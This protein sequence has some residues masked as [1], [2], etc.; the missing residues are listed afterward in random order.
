MSADPAGGERPTVPAQLALVIHFHQ[1]VGDLDRVVQSATDRCYRP[2]L[3]L[4]E[5][6]PTVPATL[7]YSGCLLEWLEDHAPDVPDRLARLVR[8]G[9]VELLTGGY[10]EPILAA[11]PPRDRLAQISRL[12]AHLED[13]FGVRPQGLWLTERVWEP[14]LP[15]TL[16]DAGVRYTVVD[17]SALRAVG[18]PV[19]A[20]RHGPH[21]T[22]SDGRAVLVYAGSAT[23][24]TLI[25]SATVGR[26]RRY[27]ESADGLLVYADDGEKFGE[28]RN[29]GARVYGEG[30]L[31]RFF[32]ALARPDGGCRPTTL[33]AH[34]RTA[35]V[36]GRVALPSGTY[37]EMSIWALPTPARRALEGARARLRRRDPLGLGPHLVGAPWRAFFAKY[38]EVAQLHQRMLRV[39]AAVAAAGSPPE[40][41][42]ALHRGQCNCTY[43]HGVFGGT[44]LT[45]LRTAAWH[46]L[47]HAEAMVVAA[48][49]AATVEVL[50]LDGDGRQEIRLS[51]AFG[52]AV[53]R[54]GDG[55]AL[56]EFD[57]RRVGANLL[58]VMARWEEAYHVAAVDREPTTTR[59]GEVPAASAPSGGPPEGGLGPFDDGPRLGLRDLVNGIP[60]TQPYEV[61]VEGAGVRL[62]TSVA[63]LAVSK[64]LTVEADGLTAT[65]LLRPAADQGWVGHFGCEIP[66]SPLALGRDEPAVLSGGDGKWVVA[67]RAGEVGLRVT[68]DPPPAA[69]A[70]PLETVVATLDGWS[71]CWQGTV[72]RLEWILQ[73]PPG[74]R[75]SLVVTLRP[76]LG[77]VSAR[78]DRGVGGR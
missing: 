46:H 2:F 6:F 26:L 16:A 72:L 38:P 53:V 42:R 12:T 51:H 23:L 75:W 37:P 35:A 48:P 13:R 69:S 20:A 56:S 7:H 30:W 32:T 44:Y 24:R 73:L 54:P 52:S 57:D 50:D 74:G 1:P 68:A 8:R 36:A 18:L 70:T 11:L 31:R 61:A 45:F 77:P 5:A 58:S 63:G 71:R 25:P 76:V 67:D 64:R 34:A 29:S 3:E 10:D 49:T 78:S 19:D 47:L 55:G 21:V 17:D 41:V 22:D 9:Q 65:Y 33:G 14:D 27:L 66:V 60:Q 59:T 62:D 40:A 28:W 39:S 43:W 4:L 15:A